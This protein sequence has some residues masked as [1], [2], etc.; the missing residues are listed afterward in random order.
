VT[1][2]QATWQR[3]A[4]F[5]NGAPQIV[6][7]VAFAPDDD[8]AT[9]Y[10][11]SRTKGVWHGVRNANGWTW[12]RVDDGLDEAF[13]I[14]INND[15]LYVAGNFGLAYRAP[16]PTPGDHN[17][18]R[19]VANITTPTYG[20][21][22][23]EKDSD[24]IHAAVWNRGVFEQPDPVSDPWLEIGG[25]TLP[26]R[27]VYEAAANATDQ[28]VAGTDRGLMLWNRSEWRVVGAPYTGTTFTVLAVDRRYYAGQSAHG[29]LYSPNGVDW[30][31]MSQGLPAGEALRVRGLSLSDTGV[32]YAAT[33][34]GI[35]RWHGTP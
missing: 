19:H 14:L 6:S 8:C 20:L 18:W 22:V 23:S 11:A 26:N 24:V 34:A 27:L 32:L 30:T 1:I 13:L 29:V 21:N 5:D 10:A 7:G 31:P 4:D 16:L 33:S 35:W 25:A 3:E 12:T 2:A 28:I 15:A 9:A 17:D